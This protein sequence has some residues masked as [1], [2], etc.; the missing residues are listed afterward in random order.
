MPGFPLTFLKY[1]SL[2]FP[3]FSRSR[4]FAASSEGGC[5]SSFPNQHWSSLFKVKAYVFAPY[6]VPFQQEEIAYAGSFNPESL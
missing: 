1:G 2:S 4:L 3:L 6:L 5:G